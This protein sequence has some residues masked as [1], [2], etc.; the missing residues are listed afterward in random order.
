MFGRPEKRRRGDPDV[1]ANVS[2]REVLP[3]AFIALPACV[4]DPLEL[5][6]V[7][8]IDPV[9]RRARDR[10]LRGGGDPVEGKGVAHVR[11]HPAR[12]DRVPSRLELF[13][14]SI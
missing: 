12:T 1:P 10:P 8:R 6:L 7:G 11:G 2:A 9:E 4:R 3:L 5:C 13:L 14:E